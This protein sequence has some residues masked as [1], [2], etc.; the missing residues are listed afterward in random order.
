M[1]YLETLSPNTVN[2]MLPFPVSLNPPGTGRESSSEGAKHN[3]R[4]ASSYWHKNISM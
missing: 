2:I 1:L 3:T 4:K